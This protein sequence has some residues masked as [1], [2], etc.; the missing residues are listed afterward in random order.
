[1]RKIDR[2][3]IHCTATK[4]GHDVDI[5]DVREWHVKGNGWTDVGYHYVIKLDGT[6]QNGRPVRKMGAGVKGHNRDTI[7]VAYVGGCDNTGQP[8]NTMNTAQMGAI[9]EICTALGRVFGALELIGHNDLTDEK[10]CPSYN[11]RETMGELVEWCQTPDQNPP[12]SI[13]NERQPEK[14]APR[15]HCR[16]C[17]RRV[18]M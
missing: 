4:P 13:R 9:Y 1:M 15:Q 14:V 10:A 17:G 6:I 3:V 12:K 8:A 11:V 18:R 7:H 5:S 2:I 16:R